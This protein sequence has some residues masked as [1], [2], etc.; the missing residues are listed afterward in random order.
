MWKDERGNARIATDEIFGVRAI[1]FQ[2][3]DAKNVGSGR[4]KNSLEFAAAILRSGN[5]AGKK[6]RRTI[7]KG[8]ANN[9]QK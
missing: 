5:V 9:G 1:G 4:V 8:I 7:R 2:A 6:N 3:F